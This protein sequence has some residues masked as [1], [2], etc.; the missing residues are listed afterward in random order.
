MANGLGIMD[1]KL[2]DP[3]VIK[4][5]KNNLVIG[6]VPEIHREGEEKNCNISKHEAKILAKH[7]IERIDEVTTEWDC[8]Q[9]SSWGIRMFPYANSRLN[10]LLESGILTEEEIEDIV[11]SVDLDG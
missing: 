8:G 5:K 4:G 7:W 1:N 11:R 6:H 10:N 3:V 9:S 2:L